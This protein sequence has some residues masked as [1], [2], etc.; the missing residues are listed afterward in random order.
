MEKQIEKSVELSIID[1]KCNG[2]EIVSL[3][4]ILRNS[5]I[6]IDLSETI[7]KED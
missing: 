6:F 1:L 5:L 2:R 4:E 3:F 7:R